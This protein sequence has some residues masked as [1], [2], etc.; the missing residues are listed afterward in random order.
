MAEWEMTTVEEQKKIPGIWY[1]WNNDESNDPNWATMREARTILTNKGSI[2]HR[3][4]FYHTRTHYL[5][6]VVDPPMIV[7]GELLI[8]RQYQKVQV[9]T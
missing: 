4:L 2:V 9:S 5:E 8:I 7:K 1:D 3:V 6:R